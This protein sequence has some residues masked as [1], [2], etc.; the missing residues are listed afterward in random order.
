MQDK[1]AVQR[2]TAM[3]QQTD[4]GILARVSS[5]DGK[6]LGKKIRLVGRLLAYE[7]TTCLAL[8]LEDDTAVLVDVS[9][10]VDS[11]SGSWLRDHLG[12]IRVIGYLEAC[13]DEMPIPTMPTYA[14]AP[15]LDPTLVV[16]AILV[17]E[18]AD[19]DMDLWAKAVEA[20][21]KGMKDET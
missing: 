6:W 14:T 17:H 12:V 11:E 7:S 13:S 5:L 1:I 19:V 2:S 15:I 4:P 18:A 10:C 8:L 21:G 16:R 3:S 9:L 20:R